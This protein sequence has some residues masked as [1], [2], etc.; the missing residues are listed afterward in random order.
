MLKECQ[1]EEFPV[2]YFQMPG[3]C[4]VSLKHGWKHLQW[5]SKEERFSYSLTK[6]LLMLI[7]L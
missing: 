7:S 5:D 1:K 2:D 4:L 3:W 6:Q